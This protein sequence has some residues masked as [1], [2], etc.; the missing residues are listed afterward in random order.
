M[1]YLQINDCPLFSWLL[2]DHNDYVHHTHSQVLVVWGRAVETS[3]RP[4]GGVDGQEVWL[5]P[6]SPSGT[7]AAAVEM[8]L[9]ATS[10]SAVLSGS[11]TWKN[12]L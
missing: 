11:H 10:V 5:K 3:A 2:Y 9:P 1:W 8:V 7:P 4:G 6:D 12:D